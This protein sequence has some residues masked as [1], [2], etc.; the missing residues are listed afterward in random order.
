MDDHE[1]RIPLS[2]E[3]RFETTKWSLVLKAANRSSQSGQDALAQLCQHYWYPLY[4]FV[5]SRGYDAHQAEDM[6]QEFFQRLIEKNYVGDADRAKG[7]F[8]TFL[9]TSLKNFLANEFDRRVA[10]KRGG[11]KR[12]LSLDLIEAEKRLAD[13]QYSSDSAEIQ[14]QRQWATSLLQRVLDE[15]QSEYAQAGQS[16]KFDVLKQF[17]T[18][19]ESESTDLVADRLSMNVSAVRVAIHRLRSRYRSMLR[20]E[21]SA[22]VTSPDEVNDEI[23]TLF[24]AFSH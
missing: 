22:T 15:L 2:Y 13:L 23:K 18:S 24:E 16:I 4:A 21:I 20:S 19:G 9:L 1:T 17:L 8:R 7:K 14:F 11:G 10:L 5:R 12:V 3:R 6:T